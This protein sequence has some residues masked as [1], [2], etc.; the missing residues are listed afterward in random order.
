L[1][2]EHPE[3]YF[4]ESLRDWYAIVDTERTEQDGARFEADTGIA[5]SSFYRKLVLGLTT[6]E[7]QPLLSGDLTDESQLL[8]RRD[9][10]E[11]L[12]GVAP[13]LTFDGDP[14]PVITAESVVWV[15]SG[16]TTSTSYPYSQFSAL[17][18]RRVN[19]AH[20]SIWATVDAYDGSVHLY[21][22]EVGG[23]DDPILRAWEGVFPGLVEAIAAMPAAVRDHLRYPTDLLDTQLALLGKYHVDDAD[24][25]FSG[26]QRWSVSAAP[27]TGVGAAADGTADPVTLFMPGDDPE[28]GGHWVAITPLSPGTSPSDSSAREELAAIV[29]ADHDDPERLRLL[30]VDVGAGRTAATP[31]VAQSAI[32]ADPE[33]A[34]TFTLLNANG[35]QVQFGPMTPLITDGA[36]FWVRPVVVRSTA[37]TA[38]PRLFGVLAVSEGLVGLADDPAQALTAAY[39]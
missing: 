19:Y 16:Y 36:L 26:T 22:T 5:L 8:Y 29:I 31:R 12:R 3:L 20:A 17:G 9:V 15:V 35:S 27:S 10:I 7:L 34:R 39:D 38:A 6:G 32:D 14:Y 4:G 24:T 13:F 21:R 2:P 23:A 1:Q 33:L 37:S 11:R 30:T 28:L 25:L 18:G